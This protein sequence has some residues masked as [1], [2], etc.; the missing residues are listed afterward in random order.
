MIQQ[1]IFSQLMLGHEKWKRNTKKSCW[2][3]NVDRILEIK[4]VIS[5]EKSA[6]QLILMIQQDIF[7]QL[8]LGHEKWKQNTK[9]RCWNENVDR[10][11]EMKIVISDEKSAKQLILNLDYICWGKKFTKGGFRYSTRKMKQQDIFSNINTWP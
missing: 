4:I 10:I 3:E 9:K 2:N 7:S 8:M 5:D 1:D 11:L 6:K